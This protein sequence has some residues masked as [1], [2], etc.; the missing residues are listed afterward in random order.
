MKWLAAIRRDNWASNAA[1]CYTEV[2]S[3][4][5]KADD[6]VEGKRRRLKKGAIP[7]VFED[8]PSHLQPKRSIERSTASIAKRSCTPTV[9]LENDRATGTSGLQPPE[10]PTAPNPKAQD[11]EPM[12]TTGTVGEVTGQ[13]HALNVQLENETALKAATCDKIVQVDNRPSSTSLVTERAK[14]K[15]KE[16]DLRSQIPRIQQAVDK[17]KVELK[18]LQEDSMTADI[19]YIK[20]KASEKQ[21]AA[22]FL[23]DQIANFKKKR[24]TWSEETTRRCV[25]LRHLSTKAYEHMRGVIL[26]LP[27]RKMLTNYIGTTSGETGFSKLVETRLLAEAKNLENLN[28][29][30][31]HLSWMRCE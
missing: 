3:R 6:F 17:Y 18:K 28:K 23:M 7:S 15:R 16:R 21:P 12:D 5:F 19:S 9:L 27:S 25:V 10:M 20:E 31:A 8:Y 1:L 24:P 11:T 4:H 14:W 29:R 30:Y 22:L 13:Q 26:K 2:C